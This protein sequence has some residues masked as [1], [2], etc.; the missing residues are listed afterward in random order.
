MPLLPP[1]H[2]NNYLDDT[3]AVR[4][5]EVRLGLFGGP[6]KHLRISGILDGMFFDASL[7]AH[8]VRH[9]Q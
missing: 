6:W 5:D 7:A 9:V 2:A 4:Q 3:L 1:P 8:E